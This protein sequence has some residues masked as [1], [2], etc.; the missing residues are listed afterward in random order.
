MKHVTI[1]VPNGYADLSSMTGTF[2]ILTR[3]N[4]YWQKI[5]NS[6]KLEIHIAG[7]VT[8]LKLEV[9]IFSIHPEDIREIGIADLVIIPSVGDYYNHTVEENPALIAWIREQ[10]NTGAEIAS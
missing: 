2:D 1:V 4:D 5:G 8:E 3:A 9:G 6:S 10:Y 7:F